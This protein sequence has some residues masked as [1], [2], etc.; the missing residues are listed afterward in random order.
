MFDPKC[1][2]LAEHFLPTGA[3]QRLKDGLAQWIQDEVESWL[4]N[5]LSEIERNASAWPQN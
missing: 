3:P 4:E 5:G 2:E 1:F